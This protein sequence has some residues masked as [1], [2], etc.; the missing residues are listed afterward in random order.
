VRGV[1]ELALVVDL[2]CETSDRSPD[3]QK[4]LLSVALKID[5][6]RA[7]WLTGNSTPT[8]PYLFDKAES[9]Y[10]PDSGRRVR[11]PKAMRSKLE[12]QIGRYEEGLAAREVLSV[13]GVE[14]VP[15][16]D[17]LRVQLGDGT[18]HEIEVRDVESGTL[19]TSAFDEAEE[20]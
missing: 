10:D 2:A 13:R 1:D 15:G 16:P 8:R 17:T 6:E 14:D 11:T 3:E 20:G 7:K 9:T 19:D 18:E 5:C 4:A 12:R